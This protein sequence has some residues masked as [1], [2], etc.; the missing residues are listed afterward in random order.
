MKSIRIYLVGFVALTLATLHFSCSKGWSEDERTTQTFTPDS[1]H[2]IVVRGV[3]DIHLI[4]DTV[5]SVTVNGVPKMME[6]T[7]V[8]EENGT[9]TI[10][11]NK[12]GEMFYP[13]TK[14]TIVTIRVKQLRKILLGDVAK[15]TCEN[16]LTG[17]EIGLV[18][19]TRYFDAD[20]KLDCTT[21]YYWNNVN[22][23]VM[24]LSGQVQELKLW[25]SGLCAVNALDL[26]T[27]YALVDTGSQADC[28]VTVNNTLE[29]SITGIG[30]IKYRGT[31]S[32]IVR[33]NITGSGQLIPL[34]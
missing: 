11:N 22:A 27:N 30:N 2:T 33:Q 9:I 5:C 12:R 17:G 26:Q 18:A 16:P 28:E 8:I 31:P 20:L 32:Q 21:F 7:S 10:K 25:N 3:F 14:N 6:K 15:V 13:K 19:E 34:Q 4:Q 24:K 1:I 29:Y 23:G